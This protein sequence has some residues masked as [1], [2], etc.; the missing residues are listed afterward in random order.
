MI[1]LFSG[2]VGILGSGGGGDPD[3]APSA[4]SSPTDDATVEDDEAAPIAGDDAA[5][6]SPAEEVDAPEADAPNEDPEDEDVTDEPT[7]D[8]PVEEEGP[9]VEEEA[10]E[11]AAEEA[12]ADA[13]IGTPVEVG[14]LSLTVTDVQTGVASVGDPMWDTQANGEFVIVSFTITNNGSS[15]ESIFSNDFM[16]LNDAGAEFATSSDTWHVED[17]LSWEE[18][19]PGNS[20]TGVLVYDVPAGTTVTG[21]EVTVGWFSSPVSVDLTS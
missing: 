15:P 14:D 12:T 1:V 16:L 18:I 20:F 11:T 8:A 4:S 3:R 9:A 6:D 7:E 5:D 21:L 19:N 17:N 10:A 13:G 2:C